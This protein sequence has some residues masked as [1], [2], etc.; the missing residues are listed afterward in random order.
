MDPVKP[1][2]S[3]SM[4]FWAFLKQPRPMPRY[5]P[6]FVYLNQPIQ[7]PPLWNVKLIVHSKPSCQSHV[8]V[9]LLFWSAVFSVGWF[10]VS[11]L[12]ICNPHTFYH[13]GVLCRPVDASWQTKSKLCFFLSHHNCNVMFG[14]KGRLDVLRTASQILKFEPKY[15]ELYVG[16]FSSYQSS[17]LLW[18]QLTGMKIWK[19]LSNSFF[20]QT[21]VAI[22][23]FI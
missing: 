17:L 22:F 23:V 6:M 13:R 4:E 2:Q 18:K 8:D 5:T 19:R 15:F 7:V 11:P 21:R 16:A 3:F 10:I 9:V 12:S 1:S 20:F 14:N